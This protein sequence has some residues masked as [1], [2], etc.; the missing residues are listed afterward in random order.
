MQYSTQ[1]G[2]ASERALCELLHCHHLTSTSSVAA[3]SLQGVLRND[4]ISYLLRPKSDWHPG[5]AY[6]GIVVE[7]ACFNLRDPVPIDR[8]AVPDIELDKGYAPPEL[9]DG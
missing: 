3:L 7:P 5:L 1:T 6:F 8:M 2:G 9:T 4:M